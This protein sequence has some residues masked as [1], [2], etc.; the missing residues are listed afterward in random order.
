MIGLLDSIVTCTISDKIKMRIVLKVE[1]CLLFNDIDCS[2]S[3][4][5]KGYC[6]CERWGY[7]GVFGGG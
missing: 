1:A 2:I 7:I 6:R 5:L 3:A 4:V